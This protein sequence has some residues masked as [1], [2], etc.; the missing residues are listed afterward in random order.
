[1]DVCSYSRKINTSC[2]NNQLS[3][4]MRFDRD[5]LKDQKTVVTEFLLSSELQ[6]SIRKEVTIQER[7]FETKQPR[8]FQ[9]NISIS[10]FYSETRI[11]LDEFTREKRNSHLRRSE[12]IFRSVASEALNIDGNPLTRHR[13]THDAFPSH[14]YSRQQ[15]CINTIWRLPGDKVE[16]LQFALVGVLLRQSLA[17]IENT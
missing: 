16:L 1:M 17:L 3:L 4:F 2:K 15:N 10:K 6:N 11:E 14:L 12:G 9:L 8:N 13:T 5:K 7:L